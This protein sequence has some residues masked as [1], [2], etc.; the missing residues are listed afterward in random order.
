MYNQDLRVF[1]NNDENS[2]N[3]RK[4]ADS[5]NIPENTYTMP[6]EI[7]PQVV[8]AICLAMLHDGK[9]EIA[10]E[11][12]RLY[13][14]VDDKKIASIKCA[15]KSQLQVHTIEV[16]TAFYTLQKRGYFI[17][18]AKEAYSNIYILRRLEWDF[19][20]NYIGGNY[21]FD[22]CIDDLTLE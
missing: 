5:I 7:R 8:T 14:N 11:N 3:M 9:L 15:C 17:K 12:Q 18:K 10:N 4:V 21:S 6:T 13:Y 2:E 19:K 20:G 16:E 22:L 1:I